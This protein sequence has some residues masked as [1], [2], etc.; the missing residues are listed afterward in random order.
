MASD[1]SHSSRVTRDDSVSYQSSR[2]RESNRPQTGSRVPR[3]YHNPAQPSRPINPTPANNQG[4]HAASGISSEIFRVRGLP[5]ILA[6]DLPCTVKYNSAT[7]EVWLHLTGKDSVRSPPLPPYC[8]TTHSFPQRDSRKEVEFWD[9][10]L[11]KVRNFHFGYHPSNIEI[12]GPW[13]WQHESVKLGLMGYTP[14]G[15]TCRLPRGFFH[16]NVRP[17]RSTVRARA[18]VKQLNRF[19]LYF[20]NVLQKWE[21]LSPEQRLQPIAREN[22][23]LA[24]GAQPNPSLGRSHCFRLPDHLINELFQH[25]DDIAIFPGI[26]QEYGWELPGAKVEIVDGVAR[27]HPKRS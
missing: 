13:L 25:W 15:T 11:P 16:L 26:C 2:P 8:I 9:R 10:L 4:Q 19:I 12:H 23:M 5:H 24:I 18:A 1:S 7:G 6:T 22:Q 17:N 14:N 21:A 27:L 3:P 20:R